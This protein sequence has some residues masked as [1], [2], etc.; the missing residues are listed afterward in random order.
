MSAKGNCYDNAA[1]ELSWATLKSEMEMNKPFKTLEETRLAVFN[2]IEVFYNRQR[3]HSSLGYRPPLDR[4]Q[5]IMR[6]ITG[7]SVSEI[8]GQDQNVSELNKSD[9]MNEE[10]LTFSLIDLTRPEK[11]ISDIPVM[12][13]PTGATRP[14]VFCDGKCCVRHCGTFR[15]IGF[16]RNGAARN[17]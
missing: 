14:Q 12:Q 3:L 17:P 16:G 9:G 15:D 8:S 7:P 11:D 4:E 6:Q 10:R 13:R 1:M 2:Y 5:Q